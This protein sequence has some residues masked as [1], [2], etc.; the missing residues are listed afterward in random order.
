MAEQTQTTPQLQRGDLVQLKS[1]SPSMV[2]ARIDHAEQGEPVV[3]CK[4]WNKKTGRIQEV[5]LEPELLIRDTGEM[6]KSKKDK[7]K[8][9]DDDDDD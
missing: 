7:T 4:F 1:G 6:G 3:L 9:D 8:K 2:V 5:T